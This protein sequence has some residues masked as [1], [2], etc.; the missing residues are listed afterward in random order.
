MQ[1]TKCAL[2][3][4]RDSDVV[5]ACVAAAAVA[6]ADGVAADGVAAAG[7]AAVVGVLW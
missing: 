7:V 4:E 1:C 6:A 5:A 3:I 2:P